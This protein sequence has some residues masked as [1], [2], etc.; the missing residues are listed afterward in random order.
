MYRLQC[1]PNSACLVLRMQVLIQ[2]RLSPNKEK[3][4]K[5]IGE[6]TIMVHV[7][8]TIRLPELVLSEISD[9]LLLLHACG[10]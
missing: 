4:L 1:A 5:I 8:S 6:L 3:L 10:I 9:L 2:I 7:L